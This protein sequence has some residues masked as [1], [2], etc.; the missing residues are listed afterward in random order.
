MN[1]RII[2]FVSRSEQELKKPVKYEEYT[3]TKIPENT[4][5]S[6]VTSLVHEIRNPLTNIILS[7]NMLE[8]SIV[9]AD[10]KVYLNIIKRSSVRINDLISELLK[11]QQP[12]KKST[13]KYSIRHL[14][15]EV[16]EIAQD[17]IILKGIIVK[18]HFSKDDD[19]IIFNRDK[20]KIAFANIVVNA[21]D[22][23]EAGKGELTLTAKSIAGV[24]TVQIEDNGCGMSEENLQ[25]ISTPYYTN[26][27][28]GLGLGLATTF[29]F[30]R[31]NN[32][33]IDVKS[34]E[35]R[36]TRFI[37]TFEKNPGN[38]VLIKSGTKRK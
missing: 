12:D 21:I 15:N 25:K 35:G 23:M 5:P 38:L 32:I 20:I 14:L 18:K 19:E 29:H 2:P 24:Y 1:S 11:V 7:V 26:K 31:S 13:E 16:I 36:G 27:P 10:L 33:G 34:E 17:Q 6:F 4:P 37:L 8:S 22:A 30:L 28:G 9:D 3:L